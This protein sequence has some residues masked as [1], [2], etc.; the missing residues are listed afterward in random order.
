MAVRH[1]VDTP[2]DGVVGTD[3]QTLAGA[4]SEEGPPARAPLD[5]V[6]SSGIVASQTCRQGQYRVQSG[7]RV[8]CHN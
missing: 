2:G 6:T 1:G 7:L 4:G 3:G 8:E 5:E